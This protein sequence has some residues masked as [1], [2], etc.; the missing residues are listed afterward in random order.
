MP[1]SSK[2]KLPAALLVLVALLAIPA[3]ADA[4][5]S[6]TKTI[7][8]PT[9]YYAKDNGKGAHKI[10]PGMNS[11]VS[12]DGEYVI[13][14]RGTTGGAEMRLF[15]VAAGKSL[16]LLNPWQEEFIFAWSP[17]STK[18]AALTG[19][20]NGPFT[21][22]A[23]DVTTGQKTKLAKGYFN[24]VSFSPDGEEVVYGL[25]KSENDALESNIFKVGVD[26]KGR[27][28]L[29][30]NHTSAYPL[31][32]PKGEIVFARFL[33]AKQR[34][35]GP[36]TELFTMNEEGQRISQLTHTKVNQFSLG[37]T[38]LDISENGARLL[39][40]FQGQDQ[41]YGVAVSTVTGSEKK[42]TD[43]P[44]SGFAGAALSPDGKTVLGTT[45]LGFGVPH[46]KVVTV[47]WSGGKQKVLVKGGYLPS[48][49]G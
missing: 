44:E 47:P 27:K 22:L 32:G 48:W 34:K 3:A 33:G 2:S 23:I 15:S 13:Y 14:E 7:G 16:K 18:V 19:P 9:V 35:Y 17:D 45:G 25:S 6:Y 37:L 26:G 31:W 40:E 46:P 39:A 28:A 11:K 41:N 36:K 49:G 10:G 12:P 1:I 43:N 38:P 8:Q 4:T 5:L 42:L 30:H 24:G 20:L 21:L 29:S